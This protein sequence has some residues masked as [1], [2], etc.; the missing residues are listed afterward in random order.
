MP[1]WYGAHVSFPLLLSKLR[2][3]GAPPSQFLREENQGISS[4]PEHDALDYR[5]LHPRFSPRLPC[6]ISLDVWHGLAQELPSLSR[7]IRTTGPQIHL[8]LPARISLRWC[9]KYIDNF[10]TRPVILVVSVV[11][12][13]RVLPVAL[14]G[15]HG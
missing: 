2:A 11:P 15:V 1:C 9:P 13:V 8:Y 5:P 6:P 4:K 3:N 10:R 12:V 7:Y 14:S